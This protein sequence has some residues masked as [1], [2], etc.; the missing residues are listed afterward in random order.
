MP[1]RAPAAPPRS[2]LGSPPRANGGE[3]RSESVL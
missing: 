2:P 3:D 1:L